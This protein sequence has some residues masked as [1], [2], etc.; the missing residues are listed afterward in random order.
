MSHLDAIIVVVML[1]PVVDWIV[2]AI[3]VVA[4]WPKPRS[5]ALTERAVSAVV[6]ATAASMA[7]GLAYVR[8]NEIRI[9]N[10]LAL[11]IL[12][13]VMVGVSIPAI[14]WLFRFVR[15]DFG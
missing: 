14:V 9:P 10:D 5:T 13:S 12:A 8:L 7:A 15:G 3:L 6:L 4:A 1:L 11:V 2:A